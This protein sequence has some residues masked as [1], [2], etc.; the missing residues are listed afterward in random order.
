MGSGDGQSGGQHG[1]AGGRWHDT[2]MIDWHSLKGKTQAMAHSLWQG[3]WAFPWRN[4]A[5]TLRERFRE[6]RLGV[7]ASSLTFTTIISLVPLF[8]VGLAVFSAFPMFGRMQT[9]LQKWLVDSLVPEAIARQVLM[10]LS[11]F[12]SKAGQMGWTGAAAL[13]VSALA[14]VLT[15]DTKLNDIWRVRRAR[16]LAQRVLVYWAVLTLGPL[17]LGGSLTLTSYVI[18]ANKGLVAALPGGLK[19]VIDTLEFVLV[20]LSL[21]LLY[22]YVPNTRVVWAHAWVG[23]VFA[24]G[25]MELAKTLLGW[26]V[27]KVPTYSAVYGAFATVPILLVWIYLVWVIVLLGAVV[28]AYL[29]ALQAGVARR[30]NG[31]GWPFQLALEMLDALHQ[32]RGQ[33]DGVGL[34][35]DALSRQLRVSDLHLEEP[36]EALLALDWVGRLDDEAQRYVLLIDPA[37]VTLAPLVQR[38]LL[39]ESSATE[40][41]W[42]IG[43]YRST[44]LHSMLS[45]VDL[46][47]APGPT[48]T[49]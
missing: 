33:A 18:S 32:R 1:L 49:P 21:V 28:V 42:K 20:A 46:K 36:L 22:R 27:A 8:A 43:H 17:L 6:D 35:L 31:P 15:I 40:M 19:L 14:L 25:G 47:A 7:T 11:Q 29:P 48:E 45:P 12:A 5:L 44:S 38:L 4:T 2:G 23:G 41:M 37:Q 24:A 30:S 26:Y 39:P 16:P 10:Y 34:S 9:A 13:L 3:A